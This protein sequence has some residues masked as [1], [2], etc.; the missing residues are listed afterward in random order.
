MRRIVLLALLAL[1]CSPPLGLSAA[2][3][4]PG[5]DWFPARPGAR[6]T[7]SVSGTLKKSATLA[8]TAADTAKW[9]GVKARLQLTADGLVVLVTRHVGVAGLPKDVPLVDLRWSGPATW[10]TKTMEGC[11]MYQI[12]GSRTGTDR[13]ATPAGTYDTVRIVNTILDGTDTYWLA[14]G[15]GIVQRV[16]TSRQ[17]QQERWVLRQLSIP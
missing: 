5:Q 12:E 10:Q 13:I 2:Q 1:A 4:A 3:T 7:Y 15:V 8:I 14:R 11:I 6:W 9:D 16:K 17:N